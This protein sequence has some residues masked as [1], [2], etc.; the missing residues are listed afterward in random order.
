MTALPKIPHSVLVVVH[1]ASL[2]F[3]LLERITPVEFWQSVTGSLEPGEDSRAAALRE[4]TEETGL[5]AP[6]TDALTD[7]GLSN[8]FPLPQSALHRYSP[9]T[10]FNDERVFSL[11]CDRPFSPRL[12]PDEHRQAVWL[13][14]QLAIKKGSSWTNRDAIRLVV[15]ATESKVS[16]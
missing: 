8:R 12:A 4:L 7:W 9:G 2:E 5:V 13:P 15:K 10:R 6:G 14:W 11:C 1:T 3:L 16:P